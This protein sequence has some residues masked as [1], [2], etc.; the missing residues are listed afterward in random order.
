MRVN[1]IW[2][3][4]RRDLLSTIR[5]RRTLVSS[6]VLPMLI[7]PLM[8]VGLPM[9]MGG[10]M[11]GEVKARQKVGVVGQL[12]QALQTALKQDE[13][14]PDGALLRGGVDLVRVADPVAAVQNGEV[15]AVV[16]VPAPLPTR[17]GNQTGTLELYAKLASLRAQSGAYAKVKAVVDNYNRQLTLGRLTELGL[18][19]K[20]LAPV[21][22]KEIDASGEQEKRS[23]ML[24]FVIPMLM[25]S[26][27]LSGAM[28]TALDGTAGEK[29]RGTLESLLVSPVRRSEVVGG[30]LLATTISALVTAV[31]NVIGFFLTGLLAVFLRRDKVGMDAE[32]QSA[33]GGQLILSGTDLFLLLLIVMSVALLLS[34]LLIA[35][36]IYAR[37]YKEAQTYV[38]PLNLLIIF[39][40]ILL[41]FADFLHTGALAYAIPLFGSMLSILNLVKGALELPNALMAVA[42]NLLCTALVSWLAL[43]SFHREEVIFRN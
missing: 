2:E 21:Q 42:S 17:A 43:Q 19:E 28:A 26:F 20:A 18:S 40:S 14:G 36:S 11:G 1:H 41:Q 31:F 27:I 29:E 3:V 30:K 8:M 4:A 35:L 7:I 33:F 32:M 9:L 10:L 37:S 15:E 22:I 16:K 25:L 39:P 6:I 34:A 23:G 13:K 24:A 12:P 5:D 38:T